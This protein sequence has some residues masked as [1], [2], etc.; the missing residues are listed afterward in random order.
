VETTKPGFD[1]LLASLAA[2]RG[3]LVHPLG[4]PA[5]DSQ[6]LEVDRHPLGV[7]GRQMANGGVEAL[8]QQERGQLVL[9]S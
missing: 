8:F 9:V 6:D 3:E 4:V 2:A 7:L 1:F 5:E